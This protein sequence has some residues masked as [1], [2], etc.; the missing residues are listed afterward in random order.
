MLD[1]GIGSQ[2]PDGFDLFA[3]NAVELSRLCWAFS[4]HGPL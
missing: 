1:L 2:D 3:G 4:N